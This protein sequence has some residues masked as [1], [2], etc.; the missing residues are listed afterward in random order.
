MG[1]GG[2]HDFQTHP[3]FADIDWEGLRDCIPPF[4]PEPVGATD[5]S[6]FDVVED[7]LSEM[8]S[9]GGV[10]MALTYC[11]MLSYTVISMLFK[12]GCCGATASPLRILSTKSTELQILLRTL[13]IPPGN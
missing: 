11:L 10:S 5:T 9:G 13:I 4:V 3:L 1:I 7:R 8:V 2:F 6:N 12:I